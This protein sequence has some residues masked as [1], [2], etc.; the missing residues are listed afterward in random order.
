MNVLTELVEQPDSLLPDPTQIP[1]A[2]LIESAAAEIAEWRAD[3]IGVHAF[4]GP[5]YP[6]QLR[7]IREMP[8][9]LFTRGR[10]ETDQR[11]VAVVG[12]RNASDSGLKIASGRAPSPTGPA[13]TS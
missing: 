10:L 2:S 8:P 13:C 9:I 1:V 7:A 5:D 4:F 11:A 6:P 3:G 12:S